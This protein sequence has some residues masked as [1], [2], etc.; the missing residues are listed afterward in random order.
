MPHRKSF[1]I[2]KRIHSKNVQT[3]D[4]AFLRI[5]NRGRI[6]CSDG[7]ISVDHFVNKLINK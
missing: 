6:L 5:N 4:R 1:L 7:R 3:L 2:P